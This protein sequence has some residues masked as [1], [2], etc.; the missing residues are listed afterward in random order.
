MVFALCAAVILFSMI[1]E[2]GTLGAC[3]R[4]MVLPAASSKAYSR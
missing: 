4:T 3:M 2:W 1:R